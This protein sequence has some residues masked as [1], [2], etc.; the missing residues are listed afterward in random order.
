MA[1]KYVAD[2]CDGQ[3]KNG[4]FRQITPMGGID[5][6]MNVMDGS[7]GWSDAGVLIP[8]RI[9]EKYGDKRIL[10][11][12]YDAMRRFAMYKIK[13]LGKHYFTSA[14]TGLKRKYRKMISNYG[15]SYGEWAEPVD[16][17]AFA[18]SDFVSPHPEE[19]TAYIVYMLEHMEK[20]ADLLGKADDAQYFKKYA[21]RTR[22]GYQKLV[23]TKKH[24]MDTDRQAKLVR[25]LYLKLLNDKQTEYAKK[26]LIKA[27][28]NYG[29][30]LGTG[31]LSTPFILYVLADINIEY[32]Y[33]LLENEEM[34]GWL[35]MPKMG[36][37]TIWESWE[38]T[39]AQGGVASL[40]HYSKGAVCEWLFD[41]MCGIKVAGERKFII[42]PKVGGSITHAECEYDSIYGK[43]VSKWKRNGN[44]IEYTI[45]VPSNTTAQIVLPSGTQTVGAGTYEI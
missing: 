12:N 23:E 3:R 17:K 37:N 42:A 25:P 45:I 8:Y 40:D 7:P 18:I 44:K 28:D 31:F 26:R 1:R 2:M 41:S 24:G 32:A 43:I 16:V 33:R 13:T 36:A 27:L 21:D 15:Q 30:R 11:N 5:F 19:T 6:Y 38:G 34:P 10:E 29:W 39:E 22:M 35:F 20:I 9:Y 4:N 14:P